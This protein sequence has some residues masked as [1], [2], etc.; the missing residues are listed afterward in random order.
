[1]SNVVE[2]RQSDKLLAALDSPVDKIG[3]AKC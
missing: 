1:M 2:G 3:I